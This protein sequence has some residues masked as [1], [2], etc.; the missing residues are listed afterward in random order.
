MK[1]KKFKGVVSVRKQNF[2]VNCVVTVRNLFDNVE[3]LHRKSS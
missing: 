3:M 2:L 1:P